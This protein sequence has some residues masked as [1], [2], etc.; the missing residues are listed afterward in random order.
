MI[1]SGLPFFG[2]GVILCT[3]VVLQV[4]ML[5]D[6]SSA[7]ASSRW[8]YDKNVSLRAVSGCTSGLSV[9]GSALVILSYLCFRSLRTRA[10]LILVHLALTDMGVA[11]AN[12]VGSIFNFDHYYQHNHTTDE[13]EE[14]EPNIS[15]Q[16]LCKT[17]ASFAEYCTLSSVLWTSCLAVYMYL[18]IVNQSQK[19]MKYFLRVSYVFC[20]GMP[21]LVT[22]WMLLTQ[23]LGYS[24]YNSAGWCSI[25]MFK[26]WIKDNSKF[27]VDLVAD[28]FGYNLWIVLT[29]ALIV[30]LYISVFFFVREQ[31]IF[32]YIV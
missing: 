24:P 30:P 28:I 12:L 8:L 31:V 26:P 16:I 25:I 18:L 2:I 21:L 5:D 4:A 10:R 17:Q 14:F 1:S 27:K 32:I 22:L 7:N 11:I 20:Y 3:T 19:Q 23:R 6:A 9:V 13:N 15:I 29:I